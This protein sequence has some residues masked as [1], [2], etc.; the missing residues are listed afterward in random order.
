MITPAIW[1]V[2]WAIL[3]MSIWLLPRVTKQ[4]TSLR[5]RSCAPRGIASRYAA[6]FAPATWT[7]SCLAKT[8]AASRVGLD[9][10]PAPGGIVTIV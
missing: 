2:C 4:G 8:P 10:G 9:E 1:I 3:K 7:P 6:I 5:L